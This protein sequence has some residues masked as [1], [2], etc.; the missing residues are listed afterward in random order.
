[1]KYLFALIPVIFGSCVKLV[2]EV[3]KDYTGKVCLVKSN[4]K[5]DELIVDNNGIGYI[6]ESTYNSLKL[7]PV[8]RDATG[9]DLMPNCVGF[10]SSVFWGSGSFIGDSKKEIKY[11]SFEIV[12]D[13]LKGIKQ[14]YEKDLSV[15]VDTTKLK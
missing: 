5:E 11:V 2:I 7:E 15:L 10:S 6:T 4:L 3:P 12:P 13:S 8:V 9:K 14:Y 1:M